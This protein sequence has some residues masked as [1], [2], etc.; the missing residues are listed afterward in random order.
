LQWV[1][2]E[3]EKGSEEARIVPAGGT[4]V[5]VESVPAFIRHMLL[6]GSKT[7]QELI[8]AT[9]LKF[10]TDPP[11]QVTNRVSV[12]L[13]RM[14]KGGEIVRNRK[15]LHTDR[16]YTLA[17]GPGVDVAAAAEPPLEGGGEPGREQEGDI[18]K[19]EPL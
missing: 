18:Y 9:V 17:S 8:E 3:D 12:A 1:A 15:S 2:T 6:T 11:E 10:D 16:T 13:T 19:G 7:R 14:V 5:K 4:E